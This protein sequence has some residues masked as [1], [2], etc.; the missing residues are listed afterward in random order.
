VSHVYAGDPYHLAVNARLNA[1]RQSVDSMI[2]G[3]G[4]KRTSNRRHVNE[5]PGVRIPP[6]GNAK[7][8]PGGGRVTT[9]GWKRRPAGW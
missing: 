1:L 7:P 2:R 3:E 9:P 5:S 8:I 6:S 4:A